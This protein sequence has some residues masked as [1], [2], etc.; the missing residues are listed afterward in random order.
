VRRAHG[1]EAIFGGSYGWASAG[2]FHHAQSQIH[3]FLNCIGG[4]VA[5]TDNYSYAAV[6]NLAPHVVGRFSQ[7]VLDDA[8]SWP[9][10][11]EHTRMMVMF[12][13]LPKKNA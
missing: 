9:V 5:H 10:I 12:G 4:Y 6:N 8:T 13:G 2:R 7:V 1:N 11:V 3:R